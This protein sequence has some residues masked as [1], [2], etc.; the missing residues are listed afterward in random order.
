MR[1]TTLNVD[2]SIFLRTDVES[3][4]S[5]ILYADSIRVRSYLFDLFQMT[6]SMAARGYMPLHAS[7]I[8]IQM[9]RDCTPAVM[10]AYGIDPKRVLPREVAGEFLE[11][12]LKRNKDVDMLGDFSEQHWDELSPIGIRWFSSNQKFADGENWSDLTTA[13]DSGLVTIGGWTDTPLGFFEEEKE[14]FARASETIFSLVTEGQQ[15]LAFDRGAEKMLRLDYQGQGRDLQLTRRVLDKMP[16]FSHATVSEL[17]DIRSE[18]KAPLTR[19]RSAM[20]EIACDLPDPSDKTY[21]QEFTDAY[22]RVIAPNLSEIDE[23]TRENTY[24]RQLSDAAVDVRTWVPSA[25]GLG[26]G[27]AAFTGIAELSTAMAGLAS[28]PLSALRA[29]SK[30]EGEIKRNRF[31]FL[32]HIGNL[33]R[34]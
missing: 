26:I 6:R 25:V 34:E 1:G 9:A 18:L 33:S 4:K 15:P 29:K 8:A 13:I 27:I 12:W 11:D 7:V 19:F 24:L 3:V 20:I 23:L 10:R 31:F 14:Y 22:R 28:I 21:E 32:W 2:P 17:I 16:T 5:V 30:Q